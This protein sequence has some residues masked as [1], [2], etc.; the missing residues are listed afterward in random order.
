[1]QNSRIVRTSALAIL[2]L[3]PVTIFELAFFMGWVEV[4]GT[5]KLPS[6]VPPFFD[7]RG[8]TGGVLTM[9]RGLEPLFGNPYDPLHR[10]VNYPRIWLILFDKA[11]ITNQNV[12]IV[13]VLF[14]ALYLLCVSH[15]VLRSTRTLETVYLLIAGLSLAPLFALERGNNDLMVFSIIYL[16]CLAAN[17]HLKSGTLSLA[18]ALKIYPIAGLS[19]AALWR[20]AKERMS[21]A[22]WVVLMTVI[23]LCQWSDMMLI[24]RGT[25]VSRLFSYGLPS[26]NAQLSAMSGHVA[27][28]SWKAMA[29]ELCVT[30]GIS[31]AV[32]L[33]RIRPEWRDSLTNFASAEMFFVFGAIYLFTFAMSSNWSYRLIFL[34]P[35]IPGA[36]KIGR[37]RIWS[38]M[39]IGTVFLAENTFGRGSVGT[40][41]RHAATLAVFLLL[42]PVI[43]LQCKAR[44]M[45][46]ISTGAEPSQ[47]FSHVRAEHPDLTVV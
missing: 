12:E 37:R 3:V 15:L 7:L 29:G 6:M 44:L 28:T 18:A 5:L 22:L 19:A 32:S 9:H 35:T 38:T 40:V 4:W 27:W 17:T 47:D 21:A 34:V 36:L 46:P 10:P 13:G 2:W 45:G 24:R 42:L 25:P 23:L 39:Y 11:G 1:M 16:G 41:L 14:A 8:L 31:L 20:P 30:G 33:I 26:L 43:V